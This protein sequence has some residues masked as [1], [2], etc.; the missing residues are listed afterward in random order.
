MVSASDLFAAEVQYWRV[1]TS[2][3]RPI[4]EQACAAGL[5]GVSSYVPWEV[6]EVEPGRFDFDGST[7]PRRD[8]IRYLDLV[9]EL[10][11]KL[12]FRPGP[13]VCNEM[14][15]GGHPQRIV[16]GE[17]PWD[18]LQADGKRAPG[19]HIARKEGHQPS[20]LH[21]AYLGEVRAWFQAVDAVA[22][23]YTATEGGP[24]HTCNLDNEI[25]YIVRDSMF[26]ADYNPCV[27]GQGRLYQQWLEAEYGSP[28]RVPYLPQPASFAII[29][30]PRALG[31][32]L[33]TNLLWYFDWIRFKEWLMA[34]YVA[35]LRAMHE[36]C[37]LRGVQ[38]YT[39]LNPHRPEG[40]PANFRKF[41][42]AAGGLV[43][44]D[45]YR[46]PWLKYS[47]YSS[48]ARVL[49]LMNASV[50]L[51][52]SAEFMGGWWF[53]DMAGNRVP[54]NH[55]E[56][57]GL[58]ALANGCKAISWFM[59]HDRDCWGDAP[60]S[61]HG[62]PRENLDALRTV[63]SA[64]RALPGWDELRPVTDLAIVYYRPYMW[65]CHLGDPSPCNDNALHVG[66]PL[67]HGAKAGEAV[68]EYE[69]LFRVAQL[70]GYTPGCVDLS[71]APERLSEHE[72][73]W[74]AAEP[75]I[76]PRTAEHLANY[77]EDGG[78]LVLTGR[79]PRVD[80][81]GKPLKFLGLDAA[82]STA[83]PIGPFLVASLGQGMVAWSE[84]FRA[85]SEP[86]EE[87]L[88]AIAHVRTL[89]DA[90]IGGPAVGVTAPPVRWRTWQPGGGAAWHEEPRNLVDAILHE[91]GGR[92]ALFVVNL[93]ERAVH[94]RLT[95]HEIRAGFL[96]EI[97]GLR[98]R[99]PIKWNAV[100]MDVDRKSVRVFKVVG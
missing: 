9:K 32:D 14:D 51:T 31:P 66:E 20:Y 22:R 28:E 26:G 88:E 12:A 62:H 40:V 36:E 74:L 86:G 4:L 69:A 21:P 59:F 41:A 63:V 57:M 11:L 79:W 84:T 46:S 49:K 71:D 56:F 87:S 90:T 83:E 94:A 43:G 8:L 100:E 82:P 67:L 25:S 68:A 10:G 38:F 23:R 73:V 92:R 91:G 39:N 19:Y 15:W 47:G 61:E 96:E 45:F 58:A 76:E 35:K 5:P 98:A 93:H 81:C 70:A 50:P 37:G 95:F 2:A 75:F 17:H 65:H 64:A 60:V 77:V 16:M 18:V 54:R 52:W 13:F 80:L 99:Y 78:I 97:G 33:E 27:V 42:D 72:M 44:Y 24:I 34:K 53:T 7:D 55:T 6:H 1:E 3:W 85:A 89:L 29:E 48:M 30:P